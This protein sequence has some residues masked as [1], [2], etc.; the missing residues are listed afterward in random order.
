MA[1]RGPVSRK[2]RRFSGDIVLLVSS[3]PRRLEARTLHLF[4]FLFP[5]QHMKRLTLQS[6]WVAVLRMAFRA[7]KVF[8]TFQKQAPDLLMLRVSSGQTDSVLQ[9]GTVW[10][11]EAIAVR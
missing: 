9:G 1:G 11:A 5:L 7:R 10:S 6:K 2:P 3:K 8:G 4:S